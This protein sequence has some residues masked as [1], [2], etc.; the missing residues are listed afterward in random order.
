MDEGGKHVIDTIGQCFKDLSNEWCAF[1]ALGGISFSVEKGEFLSI[2]G[3]SGSG[4]Q[5]QERFED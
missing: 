3:P 4:R 2:A 5:A 1:P